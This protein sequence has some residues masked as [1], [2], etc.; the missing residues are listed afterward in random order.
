MSVAGGGAGSLR[1]GQSQG[2]DDFETRL[3]EDL[4]DEHTRVIVRRSK[5][6]HTGPSVI[7][8]VSLHYNS[9]VYALR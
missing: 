5:V 8:P 9:L 4:Q 7:E 3:S 2:R 1:V 6:W